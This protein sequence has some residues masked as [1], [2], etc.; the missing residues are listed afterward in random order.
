MA[1]GDALLGDAEGYV[2]A[3]RRL[4]LALDD[5]CLPVQVQGPPGSGKTYTGARMILDLAQLLDWHRRED[6]PQ[7]WTYFYLKGKSPEDLVASREA[8]GDL[9]FDP[10]L[11]PRETP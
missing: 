4:A 6:K 1:A 3:A 5:T 10:V 7:W 2:E 11:A 9:T 8:L